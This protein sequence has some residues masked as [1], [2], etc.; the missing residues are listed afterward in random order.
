MVDIDGA[1]TYNFSHNF[2]SL[3]LAI[4]GPCNIELLIFEARI[5]IY[6]QKTDGLIRN[7]PPQDNMHLHIDTM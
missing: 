4:R 7:K 1:P 6:Q 3:L 5:E 2:A